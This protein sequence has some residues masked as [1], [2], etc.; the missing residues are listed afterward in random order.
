MRRALASDAWSGT[1]TKETNRF[2]IFPS[3]RSLK[4]VWRRRRAW[5]ISVGGWGTTRP[6]LPKWLP[7]FDEFFRI[8]R[9][10]WNCRRRRSAAIFSRAFQKGWRTRLEHVRTLYILEDL[11]W[12]DES[13]LALLIHL[14]NRITQLPVVIIGTYRDGYSENNPALTQNAG[15]ADSAGY[16]SAEAEWPVKGRRRADAKWAKPAPGSGKSGEPHL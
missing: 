11:H 7:A 6:N 16:P 4:A 15:R 8:F 5:M 9:N 14:A 12:A 1:A 3:S 10:H 13:T 2:P